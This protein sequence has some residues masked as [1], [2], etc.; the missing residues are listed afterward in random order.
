MTPAKPNTLGV[1]GT[2]SWSDLSRGDP[3]A[4]Q[5]KKAEIQFDRIDVPHLV[6]MAGSAYLVCYVSPRSGKPMTVLCV[7]VRYEIDGWA[8]DYF[9]CE[10]M[11]REQALADENHWLKVYNSRRE[12]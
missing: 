7:P 2:A 10:G 3:L 9:Y 12:F 5:L 6:G 11:T 8:E 1:T 4:D